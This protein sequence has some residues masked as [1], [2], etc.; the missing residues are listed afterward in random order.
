MPGWEQQDD[1]ERREWQELLDL[2][3]DYQRWLDQMETKDDERDE[4]ERLGRGED[5]R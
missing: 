3:E 2:D 1:Y 5:P 4:Q